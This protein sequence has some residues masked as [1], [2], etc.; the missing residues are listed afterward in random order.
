MLDEID[1]AHLDESKANAYVCQELCLASND[2]PS[3]LVLV[4]VQ[5]V[6]H[7]PTDNWERLYISIQLQDNLDRIDLFEYD[8]QTSLLVTNLYS[9]YFEIELLCQNTA[10]CTTNI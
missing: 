3:Q 4:A 8:G 1:G 5:R 10:S 2:C 6:M 9:K 7:S